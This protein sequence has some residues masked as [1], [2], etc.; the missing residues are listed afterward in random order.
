MA[1]LRVADLG[2]GEGYLTIEAARWASRVIA[3]DRSEMVLK[4]AS[5]LARRRRVRNVIWKKGDLEKLPVRDN[6]VDLAMLSQ[7]LHHAQTPARAIAEAVRICAP[8]GRVLVLD[9]GSRTG[10]R[11]GGDARPSGWVEPGQD[12]EVG[13]FTLRAGP[14]QPGGAAWGLAAGRAWDPLELRTDELGLLPPVTVEVCSGK[15]A[16]SR[17]RMNR[18][19]ALV[20]RAPGCRVCLVHPSV[21][22]FH[23]S[24]LATPSGVW[25]VDLL[26]TRGTLLNGRPVRWA[27]VGDGDRLQVGRCELRFLYAR[28]AARP[29][30]PGGAPEGPTA[31]P[32]PRPAVQAAR[33]EP[34]PEPAPE[35]LEPVDEEEL[36]GG[37]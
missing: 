25:V 14:D 20:G 18:L 4:R 6:A 15:S 31:T 36:G 28:R 22:R 10:T 21:S 35:D 13:P 24:L 34:A 33:Q 27:R 32:P 37:G 7:A 9:L 3:V 1:P 11:W 5:A 26:S 29:A 8:G 17:W 19:L 12:V 23:C 16:L 2:C 30:P